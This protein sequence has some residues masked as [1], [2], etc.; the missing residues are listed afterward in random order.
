[1]AQVT[2]PTCQRQWDVTRVP[3]GVKAVGKGARP[4]K[5]CEKAVTN[6]HAMLGIILT[7]P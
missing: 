6:N 1:M 3:A 7:E 5:C 4:E 2:C